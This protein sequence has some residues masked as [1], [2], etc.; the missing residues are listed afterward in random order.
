MFGKILKKISLVAIKIYREAISPY[1]P[2]VCRFTPTCS[3]YAETAIK[4][5]GPVKG[6]IMAGWRILRCHPFS[7]G[8]YDPV[9]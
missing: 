1:H 8:G 6:G 5:Y 7:K 2:P 3:H 4:K 9:E